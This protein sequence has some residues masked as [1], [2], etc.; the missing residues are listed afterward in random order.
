MARL[1]WQ[2]GAAEKRVPGAHLPG[3][4]HRIR[5][6]RNAGP[7]VDAAHPRAGD[8]SETEGAGDS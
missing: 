1:I 5:A 6:G 2:Q 3:T 7:I 8:G 4:R